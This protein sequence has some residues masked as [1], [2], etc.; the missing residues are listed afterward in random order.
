MDVHSKEVRSFN[1]SKISSRNTKP[2]IT[3]RK[4]CHKLG[5]RY[6]LDQKI[7][8]TKPDLVF[9]K[10][11]TVIFVHG[12]FWHRHDCKYGQVKPKTNRSFW[13][14]KF[15]SNTERDQKNYKVLIEDGWRVV[16]FWECETKKEDVL[17]EK[18]SY[19]FFL[20]N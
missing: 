13:A 1:M 8:N 19:N 11:K 20:Q 16:V 5:L 2:E 4:L 18:I 6:R 15:K 12:C 3:V 14:Q 10:Y 17:K 7:R 9:K